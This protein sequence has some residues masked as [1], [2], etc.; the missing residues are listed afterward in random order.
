MNAQ[1]FTFYWRY[2]AAG[3]EIAVS[4]IIRVFKRKGG[5]VWVSRFGPD[6]EKIAEIRNDVAQHAFQGDG[7]NQCL[8]MIGHVVF[9]A[10]DRWLQANY[11]HTRK[12]GWWARLMSNLKARFNGSYHPDSKQYARGTR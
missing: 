11:P 6:G 12:P 10:P 9:T 7:R 2:N 5:S 1:A 4:H 3:D 8:C